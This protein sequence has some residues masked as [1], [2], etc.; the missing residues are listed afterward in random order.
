MNF[1]FGQT[2]LGIFCLSWPGDSS[3]PHFLPHFYSTVSMAI[4]IGL[5]R[6]CNAKNRATLKIQRSSQRFIKRR[7]WHFHLLK[8]KLIKW[9]RISSSKFDSCRKFERKQ[10]PDLNCCSF[11][12]NQ[13]PK[14]P[15]TTKPQIS[16]SLSPST[17]N[18]IS[19]FFCPLSS[20][21]W[22]FLLP[23]MFSPINEC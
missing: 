10:P 13:I 3:G 19:L 6:V 22:Y 16:F 14:S 21:C 18:N 1:G 8:I 9:S 17:N 2:F 12:P 23:H 11:S 7:R 4:H 20:L 5:S 15:K